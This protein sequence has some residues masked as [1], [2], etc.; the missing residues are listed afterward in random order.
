MATNLSDAAVRRYKPH[1]KEKR[2]IRDAG[3]DSLYLCIAPSGR[4]SFLM[5]FRRPG[6]TAGKIVLG[7]YYEGAETAA[8]PVIGMP[9]TLAMARQ[10]AQEIHRQRKMGK[11]V[12]ADH[13]AAKHRIAAS[14]SQG[15]FG[16]AV[17]DYLETYAQ[18]KTRRWKE[19]ARLLG[20]KY[21]EDEAEP[22]IIR[23]SLAERWAVKPIAEIDSHDIWSAVDEATRVAIPGMLALRDGPSDSMGRSLYS[24]LSVCFGWLTRHRHI[25]NNPVRGVHRPPP[26]LRRAPMPTPRA[27]MRSESPAIARRKK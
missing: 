12:V 11:D 8:A 21:R 16:A 17:R 22:S 24:A 6:G 9:L 4:K 27:T 20:Y 2:V 14:T 13:K 1:G 18:K 19:T 25:A 3:T 26:P 5:R 10:L 15:T 23:G 7:P